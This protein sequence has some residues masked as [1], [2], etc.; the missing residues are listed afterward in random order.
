[1][2]INAAYALQRLVTVGDEDSCAAESARLALADSEP[3]VVAQCAAVLG[4]LEDAESLQALTDLLY[5]DAPLVARAAAAAVSSIGMAH[6]EL[7]GEAARAL[8]NAYDR[9]GRTARTRVKKELIRM[10]G[11][12]L[13]DDAEE[14]VDWAYRL[15]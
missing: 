7:K 12:D 15:P 11:Y 4:L 6:D 5:A 2:R 14:W 10:R 8:A 13:G 1:M 3:G 9:V